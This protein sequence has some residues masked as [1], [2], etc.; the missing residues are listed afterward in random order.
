MELLSQIQSILIR[1]WKIEMP[2]EVYL[3]SLDINA[4]EGSVYRFL[5]RSDVNRWLFSLLSLS[6]NME[7][8]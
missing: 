8:F 7:F 6:E 5:N 3:Y 2:R 1:E 4:L